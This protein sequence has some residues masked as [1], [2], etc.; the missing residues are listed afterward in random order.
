MIEALVR[1]VPGWVRVEAE[2][3]YPER[4]LNELVLA[5]VPLWRVHRQEE[6]VRFSCP[7][8]DYRRIRPFAR[9]ACV[10]MRMRQKHGLPFWRHRYRHRKGLLVGVCL[11]VLV[12][13]LLAPRIWVIEIVGNQKTPDEAI[14]KVVQQRGV[15]LGAY[16]EDVDIKGLQNSGPDELDTV[17]WMT[18]NPHGCVARVE[19]VERDPTPQ[20]IDLS[21]PS[22]LVAARDGKILEVESRSGVPQVKVGEAVTAGTVLISGRGDM[23]AGRRPTRAYGT[24][25]AETRRRITVSV[26]LQDSRTVPVGKPIYRP[27]FSFLCWDFPLYSQKPLQSKYAQNQL[28]HYLTIGQRTLPLGFSCTVLQPLAQQPFTRT[29]A[30]AAKEAEQQLQQ[31]EEALFLPDCYEKQTQTGRV[32]E[33]QYVLTATYVCRENIALEVPHPAS[34]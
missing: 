21:Q 31:Q 15:A 34:Q 13:A 12:L 29:Q 33:G 24:V 19:V 17:A 1:F 11:Y 28:D 23:E 3:G 8:A 5:G 20:V 2:G 18:V 6:G 22:D 25:W 30:Q 26:P 4:L 7:A 9:R 16:M 14:L 10:R 27:T 32:K